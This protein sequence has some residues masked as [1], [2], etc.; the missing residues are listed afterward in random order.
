MQSAILNP[1]TFNN[2]SSQISSSIADDISSSSLA[3]AR[4]LPSK[5]VRNKKSL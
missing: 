4:I 5:E 3:P 1:S 2:S